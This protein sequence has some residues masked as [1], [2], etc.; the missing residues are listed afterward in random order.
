MAKQTKERERERES[1]IYIGR[2]PPP[3][4][5]IQ[6]FDI[7]DLAPEADVEIRAVMA[8]MRNGR[9]SNIRGVKTK[10]LKLWLQGIQEEE[11]VK[12]LKRKKERKKE[13][14]ELHVDLQMLQ[15][16]WAA[17]KFKCM[18]QLRQTQ[19]ALLSCR[20]AAAILLAKP[21]VPEQVHPHPVQRGQEAEQQ[22][23]KQKQN[24]ISSMTSMKKS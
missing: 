10:H 11:R 19:S 14:E 4:D 1:Y 8:G 6:S 23:S 7:N 5:P 18:G 9:A 20:R 22:R 15:M 17:T 13:R 12:L 21:H 2:Y 3:G 24:S 16:L